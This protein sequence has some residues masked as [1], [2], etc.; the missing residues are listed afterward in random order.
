MGLAGLILSVAVVG[1]LWVRN[2]RRPPEHLI[3]QAVPEAAPQRRA[4]P[5]V[6][7]ASVE[8][9]VVYER[10]PSVFALIVYALAVGVGYVFGS[11]HEIREAARRGF[12]RGWRGATPLDKP[13][14]KTTAATAPQI[15]KTPAAE[16]LELAP[17]LVAA[18]PAADDAAMLESL[19]GQP[20]PAN[21]DAVA[22]V[23]APA[24]PVV[25]AAAVDPALAKYKAEAEK[26]SPLMSNV[27]AD[28]SAKDS[29]VAATA[30]KLQSEQQK[31]E[32]S[33]VAALVAPTSTTPTTNPDLSVSVEEQR[34]IIEAA[35][36]ASSWAEVEQLVYKSQGGAAYRKVKAVREAL[37]LTLAKM[38][39]AV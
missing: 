29:T 28:L 14:P 11:A 18:K 37:K 1:F 17:R 15:T 25:A 10:G 26:D 32:P 35:T 4:K 12:D 27:V 3:A 24:E 2:N 8:A 7:P 22:P 34:R 30:T 33:A 39:V 5:A 13:Q 6:V 23:V 38:A 31:V 36:Y 16:M 21:A 9:E 19:L 20:A